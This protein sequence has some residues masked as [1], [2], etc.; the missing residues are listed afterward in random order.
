[1]L[2]CPQCGHEQESG[3]FCGVCGTPFETTAGEPQQAATNA[4]G[5]AGG[6]AASQTATD[7]LNQYGHYCLALLKNPGAAFQKTEDAFVHG[8]MSLVLYAITFALSIYTLMN[9]LAQQ[10]FG[11]LAVGDDVSLPFFLI[12]SRLV[13]FTA[14]F[15]AVSFVGLLVM[16][17]A[18]QNQD[19]AKRLT[20]H[21][22]GLSVPFSAVNVLAILTGL[23]TSIKLT[24]VLYVVS[25]LSFLLF[26]PS[27]VVYEKATQVNR[28]GKTI[29]AALAVVLIIVIADYVVGKSFM[30]EYLERLD[31]LTA[32]F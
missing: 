31:R 14:V 17:K 27:L 4:A 15:I 24:I 12:N 8:L 26:I 19:T 21:Y 28:N 13:L 1:M 32:K 3:K 29:Y 9:T 5:A 23:M 11:N 25:L 6:N 22:G 7:H 20:T 2:T 16:S 30:L 18:D 10:S